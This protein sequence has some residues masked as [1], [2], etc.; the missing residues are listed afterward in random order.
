[1]RQYD[2]TRKMDKAKIKQLKAHIEG[3][4]EEKFRTMKANKNQRKNESPNFRSNIDLILHQ[5]NNSVSAANLNRRYDTISDHKKSRSNY[6]KMNSG[7]TGITDSSI[8]HNKSFLN[9]NQ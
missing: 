9:M 2:L 1:M 7:P 4:F 3:R 5:D 6:S 8:K